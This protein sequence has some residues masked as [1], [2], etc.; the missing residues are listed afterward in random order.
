MP[1][2]PHSIQSLP[3]LSRFWMWAGDVRA[4]TVKY[5]YWVWSLHYLHDREE[6]AYRCGERPA[7][8][9]SSA[10]IWAGR[11][12]APSV[13]ISLVSGLWAA[14]WGPLF[15]EFDEETDLQCWSDIPL[16]HTASLQLCPCSASRPS[17]KQEPG[18]PGLRCLAYLEVNPEL[19]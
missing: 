15:D 7:H 14:C 1:S 17:L 16:N 13:P 6:L 4:L 2:C 9:A 12:W 11:Q 10:W 8:G 18:S 5:D 19:A 3:A